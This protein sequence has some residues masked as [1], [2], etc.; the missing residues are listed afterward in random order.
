MTSDPETRTEDEF[1]AAIEGWER[2]LRK[3]W[4]K[5]VDTLD[6]YTLAAV[7]IHVRNMVK[8]FFRDLEMK[9]HLEGDTDGHGFIS[10]PRFIQNMSMR[11]TYRSQS[12]SSKMPN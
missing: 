5:A 2:K 11:S 4:P 3:V 10:S 9:I 12:I 7:L 1:R 6:A 8:A